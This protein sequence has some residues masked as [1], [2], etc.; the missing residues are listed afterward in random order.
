MARFLS[1]SPGI[2][3]P[4]WNA[5]LAAIYPDRLPSDVLKVA[6]HGSKTSTSP[7]FLRVVN[8]SAA[9]I[10]AGRNNRFG[11]PHP[12]VIARLEAAVGPS[13]LFL[14]ARDG[15]I[16]FISDGVNLWVSTAPTID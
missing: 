13:N 16:E 6:H 1:Y 10:S 2:L 7:E 9:V 15:S 4:I 12:E 5:G 3:N 8:P 11:H 14:T